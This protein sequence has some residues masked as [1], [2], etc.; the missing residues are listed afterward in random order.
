MR[1]VF[2]PIMNI[3]YAFIIFAIFSVNG[4]A[5]ENG[6]KNSQIS[7]P[8]AN[9]CQELSQKADAAGKSVSGRKPGMYE[10]IYTVTGNDKL[11][12][13]SAPGK[14]C[15]LPGVRILPKKD[16]YAV[17]TITYDKFTKILFVREGEAN[18]EGWV[19]SSR[20][21]ETGKGNYYFI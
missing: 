21:K 6:L 8:L 15:R 5:M 7:S 17:A 3:F 9:S 19:L 16:D 10:A 4:Y 20:L 1:R 11:E 2:K 14:S 13:Y 18:I 12:F